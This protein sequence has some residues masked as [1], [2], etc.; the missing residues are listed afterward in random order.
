MLGIDLLIGS[1]VHWDVVT[2]E[3]I[4]CDSGPVAVATRLGW[5][6]SGPVESGKT[7]V[8]LNPSHAIKV[9]ASVETLEEKLQSF[10][11]LESLGVQAK[12]DPVQEQ[13]IEN[14]HGRYQVSLPWWKYHE[15]LPS[16][17]DLSL[18]R[19]HGLLRR[20][21][22]EPEVL[23]EYEKIIQEQL[24]KEVIEEVKPG[25]EGVAGKVPYLSHHAVIRRDKETTKIRV[26]YDASSRGAGPSLNNCLHTGPKFNQKILE[27]LL[28]LRTYPVAVMA[29]I[30]KA[31]L[32]IYIDP[33]DR[34][35]LRFLWVKD[36]LAEKPEIV[37]YRFTRVVFGVSSSPFLLN[38]TIQHHMEKYAEGQPSLVGKISE[39][40]YVNDVVGGAGTSELPYQGS[41]AEFQES[42]LS[43]NVHTLH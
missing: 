1:D 17:Y 29:D 38:A 22:H 42:N 19:L 3:V 35:V 27:I 20:L 7:N 8:S 11:E 12:E 34:D 2:G 10:W 32:M 31:F 6:L 13:F 9:E 28:H 23:S 21:R 25:D 26:V 18:K 33:K 14:I 43:T 40:I 41:Q 36:P 24:S 4:K 5:V 39:S 37:T 15:P 30:E 16:N